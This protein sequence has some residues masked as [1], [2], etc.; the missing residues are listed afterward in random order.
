MKIHPILATLLFSLL[1]TNLSAADSIGL[2]FSV[3]GDPSTELQPDE[4][5]GVDKVDQ[6]HWNN[7]SG[8]TGTLKKITDN[9]GRTVLNSSAEWT[10][11][12]GDTAWRSL[13]GHD[14]GFKEN[15]LKLQKGYIQLGASLE[16]TGVPYTNYDVYVYF[17]AGENGGA[18][19]VT[20]T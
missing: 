15:N 8:T 2:N 11:P 5:A 13:A 9:T 3:T 10:V 17:N 1:A 20:I 16:V 6:S 18:G 7:L 14:W 4:K 12:P 19:K